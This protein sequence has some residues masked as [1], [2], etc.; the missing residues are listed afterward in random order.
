MKRFAD[1][2]TST[3]DGAGVKQQAL[4]AR[5]HSLVTDH[6]ILFPTDR[7]SG[8]FRQEPSPSLF[9]IPEQSPHT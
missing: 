6:S 1:E 5:F 2:W 8:S 7:L 3:H 4:H 9:L